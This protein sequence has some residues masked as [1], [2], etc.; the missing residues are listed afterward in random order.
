MTPTVWGVVV[1]G[2][3]TVLIVGAWLITRDKTAAPPK[4]PGR[5]IANDA[6]RTIRSGL[7]MSRRPARMPTGTTRPGGTSADRRRCA[8]CRP[9]S[10]VGQVLLTRRGSAA[11][12]RESGDRREERMALSF[13]A[14]RLWLR[15]ATA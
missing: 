6:T 13:S 8:A 1:I 14:V 10:L 7:M 4:P 3:L 9:S 2:A 15:P 12:T 11:G 5:P